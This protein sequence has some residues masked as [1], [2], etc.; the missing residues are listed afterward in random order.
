ML[1]IELSMRE[2]LT[3]EREDTL[4]E[5]AADFYLHKLGLA[6][7]RGGLSIMSDPTGPCLVIG[8]ARYNYHD[9]RGSCKTHTNNPVVSSRSLIVWLMQGIQPLPVFRTSAVI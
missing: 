2:F 7:R 6:R 3:S 8:R 4:G 5:S 1:R 9:F